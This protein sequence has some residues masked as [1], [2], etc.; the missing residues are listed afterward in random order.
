MLGESARTGH[1]AEQYFAGYLDVIKKVGALQPVDMDWRSKPGISVK[2][3]A[4]YHHYELLKEGEVAEHLL[5]RLIGLV[6]EAAKYNILL[7]IDAEDAARFDLYLEIFRQAFAG[8]FGGYDGFGLAVQAYQKRAFPALDYLRK[9]SEKYNRLIPIRL[10]KGAYWDTEIKN[11][12]VAGLKNYPVF[13]AKEN[14][15]ISY[16]ACAKKLLASPE[17]FYPQFATHNALSIA[18]MQELAGE[19]KFELQKLHGMGDAVYAGLAAKTPCRIYAPIGSFHELLPYLIRRLLENGA[20]NSFVHK[21]AEKDAGLDEILHNPLEFSGPAQIPLP[22]NIYPNWKNSHG[23]DLGN[24]WELK[25]LKNKLKEYDNNYWRAFSIIDGEERAGN[26]LIMHEPANIHRPVGDWNAA[27][28]GDAETAI[29]AAEKGFA[30]W[31]ATPVARRAECLEKLADLL[32]E[33]RY[34]LIALCMREAGKTLSDSIAE[35]REAEDFC[36]YYAAEARRVLGGPKTLPG[37]AGEHNELRLAPRGI[38]ICISPWN[39]PL[40]IFLGQITAALA[41]GN[42]VIAKP[43]EQTPLI[44]YF[45]AK[46]IHRA[47]VPENVLQLVLGTGEKIGAALIANPKIAGVAFT[48]STDTA[49]IINRALA[50]KDGP[51]VPMVAETGGQNAMIVDSSALLEQTADDIVRSA[52]GSSGQRCSS[53][54]VL[55][56]QEEIADK[57]IALLQGILAGFKIKN[58][59]EFDADSGPVIDE[60]ACEMLR[61]HSEKMKKSAIALFDGEKIPTDKNGYFVPPYI[62]EIGSITELKKEIFGPILHVI[63]FNAEDLDRIISDINTSE[64]GLTL[65]LQTRISARAEYIAGAANVGNCYVNRT[66]IGAVVGVQPFGGEKLSGTGPKAG[67]P[68]YLLRFLTERVYTVNTAAVGGDTTLLG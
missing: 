23:Y 53:L 36:R 18:T 62:F 33:N 46:L 64:F 5:P 55:Y 1:Q 19:N 9:L 66:Q 29:A 28:E 60:A 10:V 63:R 20:N 22:E 13:T 67:G 11:A 42:A 35:V 6:K 50:A 45:T 15:D 3:S 25:D 40:A 44:S 24:I 58:T 17:N 54:R 14:T 48:G 8:D 68:H 65:G 27:E 61:A 59:M 49:R 37:P 31:R 12:Q 56:V 21:L 51:I 39:F 16:M 43:A 7:T 57:L 38:F 47:G 52:F 2:L 41:A 4:L 34:E 32:E 26:P 30:K